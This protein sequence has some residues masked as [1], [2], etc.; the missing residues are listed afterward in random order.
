M[1]QQLWAALKFLGKAASLP[2]AS[3][4]GRGEQPT[5]SSTLKASFSLANKQP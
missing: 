2:D 3:G 5:V 1:F 4:Q